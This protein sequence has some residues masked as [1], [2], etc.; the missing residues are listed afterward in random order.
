MRK[1]KYNPKICMSIQAHPDD[2]EFTIAGTLARWAGAGCR[3]ISVIVT[4]GSAGSNDPRKT[5]AD[6]PALARQRQAE[7]L[8]A[9]KILGIE[10]TVFLGYPDGE[11]VSSLELRKDLTRLIRRFKPE[12]VL[13]GDPTRRFYEGEYINHP[14]HRA[15]ADAAVDAVFPSAGTQLIFADLLDEGLPPHKV[16]HLFLWGSKKPDTWVDIST[17]LDLKIKA[18]KQHVSQMGDWDP[19]GMMRQWASETGR[20][21]RMKAAEA[22]MTMNLSEM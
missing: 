17:T 22:F 3:V 8:S 18:L 19:S 9:N 20:K 21:K 14:D 11:L 15:T 13:T 4:D 10:E 5:S 1:E 12:I 2:Q 7:Q 6:K 16:R